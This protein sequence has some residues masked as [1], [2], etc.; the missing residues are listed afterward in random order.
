MLFRSRAVA[1]LSSQAGISAL[2]AYAASALLALGVFVLIAVI[3]GKEAVKNHVSRLWPRAS[4]EHHYEI[5]GV[6]ATLST[7][8]FMLMLAWPNG[9]KGRMF[10]AAAI[11]VIGV[12]L[13]IAARYWRGHAYAM[14]VSMLLLFTAALPAAWLALRYH[15]AQL[16]AAVR[17]GLSG[18]LEDVLRR[19][20]IIAH[21]LRRWEPDPAVR[22]TD[23][24]TAWE[25]AEHPEAVP[26]PGYE[27]GASPAGAA[28][29]CPSPCWKM[30]AFAPPPW[31]S[32]FHSPRLND[33]MQFVWVN[34]ASSVSQKQRSGLLRDTRTIEAW[35]TR[36]SDGHEVTARAQWLASSGLRNSA[37]AL[38]WTK[39]VVAALA[40]TIAILLL[41][42]MASRRLVGASVAWPR[43]RSGEVIV[44]EVP[45]TVIYYRSATT[46]ELREIVKRARQQRIGLATDARFEKLQRLDIAA[47]AYLLT[48]LD[49]AVIEPIRRQQI[50]SVL[51]Q[52][53]RRDD[54]DLII[55]AH[56]S[57]LRR[58]HHPEMYPEF[59]PGDAPDYAE[60]IR[61]DSVLAAFRE[62]RQGLVPI[63]EAR[64]ST[65][66]LADHHRTWKLCTRDERLVLH[67]LATGKLANPE[68]EDVIGSLIRHGL[69]K[70]APRPQIAD[71]D[72]RAFVCTAEA[73]A[74]IASWQRA[75]SSTT[76]KTIRAPVIGG[77]LV[78]VLI[79]VIWFSWAG[80]ETFKVFSTVIMA[81]VALLGHLTSAFNFVRT[82]AKS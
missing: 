20:A 11:V 72:F 15:D 61:W 10:A 25:L 9:E 49:L 73:S 23:L 74:D 28:Q 67:Q 54:V 7:V 71:Q 69:V 41:A 57:P 26:V 64:Q 50:L 63:V 14:C 39:D 52:V 8:G 53:A 6:A 51:E 47:G 2:V 24:P 22:S 33:W 58:L 48:D 76:W 66:K 34:T 80:G 65:A 37:S 38:P 17:D 81:A 78:L 82:P 59:R 46:A 75:A 16:E 32:P 68:N 70:A 5:W 35:A 79:L 60:L 44:P 36:S 42:S 19:R 43:R 27:F 31:A 77:L 30:T 4:D 55:T 45:A 1:E 3:V 21:D 13:T 12:V 40:A 29:P 18:A 56:R 62:V